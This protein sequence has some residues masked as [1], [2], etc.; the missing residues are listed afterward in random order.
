MWPTVFII[1]GKEYRPEPNMAAFSKG[2]EV[3]LYLRDTFDNSRV[4]RRFLIT[5]VIFDIVT[6]LQ[7]VTVVD[8]E[9][10]DQT[11]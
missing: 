9:D 11:T 5:Q 2:G 7:Y 1:D 8:F 3:L 4:P 10:H 6:P